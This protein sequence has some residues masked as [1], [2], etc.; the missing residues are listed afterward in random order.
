MSDLIAIGAKLLAIWTWF[1]SPSV[2]PYAGAAAAILAAFSLQPLV[3]VTAP[4]RAVRWAIQ[5]AI[6]WLI[7][8][9]LLSLLG[10]GGNGS[11]NDQNQGGPPTTEAKTAPEIR[12][13]GSVGA[14]PAGI[15]VVRFIPDP[16]DPAQAQAFA[17]DLEIEG[18][19]PV[20][21]RA[22]TMDFLQEKV[23]KAFEDHLA[24]TGTPL[25]RVEI[26]REPFPGDPCI[27]ALEFTIHSAMP[28]T[29]VDHVNQATGSSQDTDR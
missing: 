19:E 3:W 21:I 28:G 7:A 1:I 9:W 4:L 10:G 27:S 8:A 20:P 25:A 29:R 26:V 17:C 22:S 2:M 16:D 6:V 12:P 14:S 11:K 5:A 15:V 24:K 13:S 18:A 23:R